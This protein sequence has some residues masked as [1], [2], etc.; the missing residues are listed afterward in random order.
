MCNI[1]IYIYLWWIYLVST[2]LIGRVLYSRSGGR[3]NNNIIYNIYVSAAAVAACT[4]Q[5]RRC[6]ATDISCYF[7]FNFR[8]RRRRAYYNIQLVNRSAYYASSYN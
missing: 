1:Y 7:S 5:P 2:H 3:Y 4:L 6:H 8:M